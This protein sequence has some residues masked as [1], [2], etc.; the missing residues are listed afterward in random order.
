MESK[1]IAIKMTNKQP[2]FLQHQGHSR[3]V[4]GFEIGKNGESS[5]LM[6]DPSK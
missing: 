4:V 1:G 3:T 2:L 5:V 6:F